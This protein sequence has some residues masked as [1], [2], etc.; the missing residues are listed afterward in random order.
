MN[1]FLENISLKTISNIL[2][3]EAEDIGSESERE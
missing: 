1:N 2:Y 3:L